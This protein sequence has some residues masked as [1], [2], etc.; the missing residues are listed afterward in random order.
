MFLEN[1]TSIATHVKQERERELR[2][3]EISKRTASKSN[4][5]FTV[6]PFTQF[7]EC[8]QAHFAWPAQRLLKVG[9][10]QTLKWV[11]VMVV[12]SVVGKR[13]KGG[14]VPIDCF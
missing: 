2:G 10:E 1:V 5:L 4:L 3:R 9:K 6:A 8:R 11:V 12:G 13:G 14:W 7:Q